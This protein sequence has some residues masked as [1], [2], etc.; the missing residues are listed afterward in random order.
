VTDSVNLYASYSDIYEPQPEINEDLRPLGPAEGKSYEAGVKAELLEQRL[1]ASLAV[2]S[3]RQDNYAE[4]AGFDEATGQ[5]YY[6]GIDVES[7][8]FELEASG[9]ITDNWT[10]QSGFT[11]T[12][13]QDPNSNDDVR[14][15]I[16]SKTFNLGTRYTV[17]AVPGLQMGATVKWDDDVYLETDN[18]VIRSDAHAVVSAFVGYTFLERYDVRINGFNL[19][20][21]KYLA[22]LYWDQAFYAPP[23]NWSVT[24]TV[25]L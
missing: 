11:Y 6:A 14:T 12:D 7:E 8:G 13:L 10:L 15:Y 1:L 3:A 25:N 21:E 17:A 19:T 16:P 22:S 23:V 24:F 20:D 4:A 9:A 2:F 5:T 18:G